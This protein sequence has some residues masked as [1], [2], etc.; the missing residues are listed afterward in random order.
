[1]GGCYCG[2]AG[3]GGLC[4][5]NSDCASNVCTAGHCVGNGGNGGSGGGTHMGAGGGT[6]SAGGGTSGT[7]G[8]T[9]STG[10]GTS[11]TGGGCQGVQCQV[12]TCA[13]G[14]TTTLTGS[15][16]DPGGNVPLYNAIVYVPG[17]PLTAFTAGP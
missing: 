5:T 10:G 15:V 17:K 4:T 14:G 12:M 7:G 2:P 9:S 6:S 11:G 16:Y 3:A 1:W 8:G 13:D